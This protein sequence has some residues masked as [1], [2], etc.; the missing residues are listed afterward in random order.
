MLCNLISR[1]AK[2]SYQDII[3][4]QDPRGITYWREMA[5]INAEIFQREGVSLQAVKATAPIIQDLANA[6]AR[7]R[8]AGA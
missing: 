5:E 2:N 4:D 8:R 3:S 7:A 6:L 1:I